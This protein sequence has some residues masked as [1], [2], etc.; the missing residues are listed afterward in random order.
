MPL[1]VLSMQLSWCVCVCVYVRV[2][3][4]FMNAQQFLNL[5]MSYGWTLAIHFLAGGVL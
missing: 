3:P 2:F 1:I 5:S 4:C